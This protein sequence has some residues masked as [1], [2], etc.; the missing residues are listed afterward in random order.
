[1]GHVNWREK[2]NLFFLFR[3][4]VSFDFLSSNMGEG[5]EEGGGQ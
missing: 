5:E 4:L 1:M 2:K 3:M